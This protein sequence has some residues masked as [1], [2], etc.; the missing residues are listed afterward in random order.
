MLTRCLVS[1]HRMTPL[2]RQRAP[3]ACGRSLCPAPAA[4][5]FMVRDTAFPP[6]RGKFPGFHR[7]WIFGAF[8]LRLWHPSFQP[9]NPLFVVGENASQLLTH[10]GHALRDALQVMAHTL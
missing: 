3:A 7:I 5:W 9:G 4:G 6:A 1:P 2:F 8:R 10:G